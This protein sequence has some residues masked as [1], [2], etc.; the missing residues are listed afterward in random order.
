MSANELVRPR[1]T[2]DFPVG[3]IAAPLRRVRGGRVASIDLHALL[4]DFPKLCRFVPSWP[5][6]ASEREVRSLCRFLESKFALV[7]ALQASL[8]GIRNS[9]IPF[10]NGPSA[11]AYRFPTYGRASVVPVYLDGE[12]LGFFDVKGTGHG[13]W[14]EPLVFQM[15]HDHAAAASD[16]GRRE[17]RTRP[18]ASGVASLADGLRETARQRVL[19][20]D[21]AAQGYALETVETY[22]TMELPF[23]VLGATPEDDEPAA[24]QFRQANYGRRI[25]YHDRVPLDRFVLAEQIGN[26]QQTAFGA[27]VDFE[28]IYVVSPRYP[29]FPSLDGLARLSASTW[30]IPRGGSGWQL[31]WARDVAAEFRRRG[32]RAAVEQWL[33]DVTRPAGVPQQPIAPV[34]D[35]EVRL[36]A[37]TLGP[38]DEARRLLDPVAPG[39]WVEWFDAGRTGNERLRRARLLLR[40]TFATPGSLVFPIYPTQYALHRLGDSA[41]RTLAREF[42]ASAWEDFFGSRCRTFHP[43]NNHV[44]VFDLFRLARAVLA[45]YPEDRALE[46]EIADYLAG[47]ED[48]SHR[49][50]FSQKPE[51]LRW[52]VAYHGRRS[53]NLP[54]GDHG[55]RRGFSFRAAETDPNVLLR[56]AEWE[57]HRDP[58]V[59]AGARRIR[60]D[61]RHDW[62]FRRLPDTVKAV[63]RNSARPAGGDGDT[64]ANQLS[65][66]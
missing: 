57:H 34:R 46:A 9:A 3:T 17:V 4:R 39:R 37:A 21:F 56:I 23:D 20:R 36:T 7:S 12:L 40:A 48:P 33:D 14:N 38:V 51:I 28:S 32:D 52:L 8:T 22:F 1:T 62:D 26:L 60:E 25:L 16:V 47:E 24:L 50:A 58:G 63:Y 5:R 15:V 44:M 55:L 19:Q 35:L 65:G 43:E 13:P 31:P 11:E 54:P 59:R 42:P 61:S 49:W 29:Q 64:C 66:Q 6:R 10:E 45:R 2:E 30:G 27:M 41:L 53:R 18:H